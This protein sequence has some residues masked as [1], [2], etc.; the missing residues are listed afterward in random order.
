MT[1]IDALKIGLASVLLGAGRASKDEEIDH[2]AGVVLR[3]TV[4]DSVAAGE[5]LCTL[6]TARE[7]ALRQATEDVRAA[8]AIADTRPEKRPLIYKTVR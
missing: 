7:D 8:F 5:T 6:Y 4:G 1:A 3:K 2:S